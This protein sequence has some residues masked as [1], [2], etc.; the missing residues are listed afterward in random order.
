M[1]LFAFG[2]GGGGGGGVKVIDF[3]ICFN[4]VVLHSNKALDCIVS[5]LIGYRAL[6]R[7]LNSKILIF[8]PKISFN[9][10]FYQ[11]SI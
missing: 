8:N 5:S 7:E 1:F 4:S 2:G 3:K 11:I 9:E 6:F 10:L